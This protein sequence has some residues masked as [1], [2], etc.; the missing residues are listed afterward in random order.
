MYMSLKW[1]LKQHCDLDLLTINQ[2]CAPQYLV[3]SHLELGEITIATLLTEHIAQ[4]VQKGTK[5]C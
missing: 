1:N 3:E 4:L 2:C 5:C